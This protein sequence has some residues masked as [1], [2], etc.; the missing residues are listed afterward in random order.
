MTI[1]HVY[2]DGGTKDGKT[3]VYEPFDGDLNIPSGF[4]DKE[5]LYRQTDEQRIVD[6]VT[7]A[8]FRYDGTMPEEPRH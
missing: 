4:W 6:G 8:V 5:G 3:E 2:F 1:T 7:H